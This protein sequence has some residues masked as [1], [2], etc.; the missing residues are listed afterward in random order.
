MRGWR[1]IGVVLSAIWFVGFGAWMWVAGVN[2]HSE[3]LGSQFSRCSVISDARTERLRGDDPQFDQRVAE[4]ALEEKACMD[5]ASGFFF[6]QWDE[7]VSHVWVL[8]LI[9]AA[10][11]ALFWLLAWIVVSV[12]RWVAAGFRQQRA[13]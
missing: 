1:R 4:I 6:Q 13:G 5:K 9:D 2:Q 8:V 7:L 12:G 11:I 3:F 10:S